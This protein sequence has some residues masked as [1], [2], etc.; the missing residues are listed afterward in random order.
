MYCKS[1]FHAHH[2]RRWP[3]SSSYRS[4]PKATNLTGAWAVPVSI[5]LTNG[6]RRVNSTGQGTGGVMGKTFTLLQPGGSLG[7][8]LRTVSGQTF[9]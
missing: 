9:G 1:L 3:I 2:R 5:S 4:R 7:S 8:C 6:P